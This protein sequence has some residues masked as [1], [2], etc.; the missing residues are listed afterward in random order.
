MRFWRQLQI[1]ADKA[2]FPR[3]V[4]YDTVWHKILKVTNQ[5][6]ENFDG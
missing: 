1:Y 6:W 4:L 3:P 2:G 5:G